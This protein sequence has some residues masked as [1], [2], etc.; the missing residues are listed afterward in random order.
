[1]FPSSSASN[2]RFSFTAGLQPPA[3]ETKRTQA[4]ALRVDTEDDASTPVM[5]TLQ[6]SPLET[7]S[8]PGAQARAPWATM[9]AQSFLLAHRELLARMAA[10]PD[11]SHTPTPER[12]PPSPT[13]RQAPAQPLSAADIFGFYDTLARRPPL[14]AKESTQDTTALRCAVIAERH[15]IKAMPQLKAAEALDANLRRVEKALCEREAAWIKALDTLTVRQHL[16]AIAAGDQPRHVKT[17]GLLAVATARPEALLDASSFQ[18]V[19][20]TLADTLATDPAWRAGADESLRHTAPEPSA[21]FRFYQSLRQSMETPAPPWPWGDAAAR[22]ALGNAMV[23]Q[24]YRFGLQG[25]TALEALSAQ[26]HSLSAALREAAKA[27][28]MR[29]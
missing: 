5:N 27:A 14:T 15:R 21:V 8:A 29:F 17:A 16:Q 20:G 12:T 13:S 7:K 23:M 28:F 19:H 6:A 24:A 4:P 10:A 22:E 3:A 2:R 9:D 1:M 26:L 18:T 25:L 11:W